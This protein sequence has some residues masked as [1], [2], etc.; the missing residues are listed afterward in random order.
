[1]APLPYAKYACAVRYRY[2][3]TPLR[4]KHSNG[5]QS[6]VT[7]L[8]HSRKG[9]SSGNQRKR[10]NLLVSLVFEAIARQSRCKRKKRKKN[11][12]AAHQL[13]SAKHNR[14][15]RSWT[16]LFWRGNHDYQITL[17]KSRPDGKQERMMK[18]FAMRRQR[19]KEGHNAASGP[20]QWDK[21][22]FWKLRGILMQL[23]RLRDQ[24]RKISEF[25]CL[26]SH[27]CTEQMPCTEDLRKFIT[28][29]LDEQ[30]KREKGRRSP[31]SLDVRAS[32]ARC[33]TL[34]PC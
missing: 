10:L 32:C 26:Y 13:T 34:R 33:W 11:R 30:K 25:R 20:T 16:L 12:L 4:Q 18:R 22:S 8:K 9:K 23:S 29:F 27:S 7:S 19:N 15:L 5:S 14:W 6:G 2:T 24:G 21:R 31:L 17:R 3:R 28:E 1:M